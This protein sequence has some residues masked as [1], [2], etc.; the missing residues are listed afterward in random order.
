MQNDAERTV[1]GVTI[2]VRATG[3]DRVP[4]QSP[5]VV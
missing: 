1:S 4:C 2:D 3:T 5:C